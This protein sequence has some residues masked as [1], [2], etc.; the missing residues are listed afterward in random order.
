M[1]VAL[2]LFVGLSQSESR[3]IYQGYDKW[4]HASV[5]FLLWWLA[6]ISLRWH[7]LAI[8]LAVV[9]LGGAEELRQAFTPGRTADWGDIAANTA[10]VLLAGNSRRGLTRQQRVVTGWVLGAGLVLFASLAA[11]VGTAVLLLI[12]VSLGI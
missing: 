6:R 1:A 8:S 12:K 11:T 7:T 5:F 4:L 2:A 9:A 3:S 10:G